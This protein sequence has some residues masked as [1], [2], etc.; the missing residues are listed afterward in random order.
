MVS[1]TFQA[2][3]SNICWSQLQCEDF[4]L[5]NGESLGLEPSVCFD[6]IDEVVNIDAASQT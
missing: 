6:I 3:S 4:S 2:A 1:V 5:G